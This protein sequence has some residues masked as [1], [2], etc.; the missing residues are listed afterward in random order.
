MTNDPI[1][2]EM[3]RNGQAFAERHHNDLAEMCESLRAK[4][5]RSARRVVRL[6]PRRIV[7]EGNQSTGTD[8]A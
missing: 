7:A 5:A 2:D 3:R 4:E 8:R 6:P 1:V